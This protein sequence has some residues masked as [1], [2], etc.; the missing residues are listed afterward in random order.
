MVELVLFFL[1]MSM[2]AWIGVFISK[3]MKTATAGREIE[4]EEKPFVF[5]VNTPAALSE[6][7]IQAEFA[8]SETNEIKTDKNEAACA[9]Y[10][11][12]P[13]SAEIEK[14]E[15]L[16]NSRWKNYMKFLK[17]PEP[18][19]VNISR[20]TQELISSI[21]KMTDDEK[22]QLLNDLSGFAETGRD[23]TQPETVTKQLI[24]LVMN[25]SL[26]NRCSVLGEYKTKKGISRR[27]YAR[28]DYVTPV[29]FAVKGMLQ[30][31]FTK[32]IS[33][34][35]VFIETLKAMDLNYAPGDLITMNFAHPHARKYIKICGKIARVTPRAIAVCFTK[36]L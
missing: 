7:T 35:G 10:G 18:A 13:P 12:S 30:K 34:N 21:M 36:S 4:K 1:F 26:E 27:Q 16:F 14:R 29:Y 5:S 32:N 31:E 8:K 3:L 9:V 25:M 15:A 11:D 23:Q 2:V 24:E 6:K 28:M 22:S 33:K 17:K 20:V 19:S